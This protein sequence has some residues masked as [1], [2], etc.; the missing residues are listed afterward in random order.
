MIELSPSQ[1]GG[2]KG[3]GINH[4]LIDMWD[5]ILNDLDSGSGASCL[6]SLDI[7]K[8]FNRL[9]N[10]ACMDALVVHGASQTSLRLFHAFLDSF[11]MRA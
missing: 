7:E 4:M 5:T 8:A 10:D 2:R 11:K 6:I 3:Q 9:S 1:Y